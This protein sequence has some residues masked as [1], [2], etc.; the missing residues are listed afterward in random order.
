MRVLYQISALALALALVSA[1]ASKPPAT[2]SLPPDFFKQPF[3]EEKIV[4]EPSDVVFVRFYLH[5]EMNSKVTVWTD[6][7]ISLPFFQGLQVAGLTPDGLQQ[8]LV[9]LYSKEFVQ[10]EINVV[11]EQRSQRF[12][13]VTGA[14]RSGGMKPIVSNVTVGMMLADC[15]VVMRDAGLSSVILVRRVAEKECKVY[16]LNADFATGTERDVYLEPGDI[17]YVP[18]NAVTLV[19][20][21]VQKYIRDIVP[22]NMNLGIGMNYNYELSQSSNR[23]NNTSSSATPTS[24]SQ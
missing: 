20:D 17:L 21:F 15:G 11:L 22:P 3:P 16:Q 1:C 2:S 14:V 8:K 23:R 4:I 9:E 10:P 18:R 7:K 5:P 13:Y 12:V 19:G 6:G 24:V